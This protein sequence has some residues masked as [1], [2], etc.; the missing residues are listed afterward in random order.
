MKYKGSEVRVDWRHVGNLFWFLDDAINWYLIC[1]SLLIF[2]ASPSL[3]MGI[4]LAVLLAFKTWAV[5]WQRTRPP[6]T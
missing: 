5:N 3:V 6:W 2:V 4:V 1:V